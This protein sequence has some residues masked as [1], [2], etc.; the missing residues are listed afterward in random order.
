MHSFVRWECLPREMLQENGNAS[1]RRGEVMT[2]PMI[3][4]ARH[5]TIEIVYGAMCIDSISLSQSRETR[6]E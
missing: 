5:S 3:I 2:C 4:I 6:N 1:C